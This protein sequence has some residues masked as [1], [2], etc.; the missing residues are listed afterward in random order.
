M[1]E[2]GLGFTPE[3]AKIAK[4]LVYDLRDTEEA[5]ELALDVSR[6]ARQKAERL[7]SEAEAF[8]D[9]AKEALE[10]DREEE[11]RE[12]LTQRQNRLDELP[13]AENEAVASE[14]RESELRLIVM[15]LGERLNEIESLTTRMAA[16][17]ATKA[18]LEG[19]AMDGTIKDPSLEQWDKDRK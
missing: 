12:F 4:E 7:Q 11:A 15:Q 13:D 17:Q 1:I 8:Y 9:R 16:G 3:T 19:G 5:L 18:A 14:G 2:I 6:N 10:A